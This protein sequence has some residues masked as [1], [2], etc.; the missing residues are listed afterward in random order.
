[1]VHSNKFHEAEFSSRVVDH[2]AIH[3]TGNAQAHRQSIIAQ[4]IYI[5][6]THK[7]PYLSY[8]IFYV[9]FCTII[10]GVL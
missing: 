4:I 7:G 8:I 2:T 1:M 9:P 3:S 10:P 5:R 6:R